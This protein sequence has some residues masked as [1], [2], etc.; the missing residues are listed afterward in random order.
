M[1]IKT[2]QKFLIGS[3]NLVY[4]EKGIKR[5]DELNLKEFLASGSKAK[6]RIKKNKSI[7]SVGCTKISLKNGVEVVLGV[8]SKLYT[9]SGW[10]EI[11][12]ITKD[13]YVLFK[14]ESYVDVNEGE[15]P[16][17]IEKSNIGTPISIPK[18][19]SYEFSKWLGMICSKGRF[20]EENG[21]VGVTSKDDDVIKEFSRLTY[22]IF[23]LEPDEYLDKR[24]GRGVFSFIISK[25]LVRF[26]KFHIGKKMFLRKVPSFILNSPI[27]TQLAFVEGL[28][29][30]G[31][32]EEKFIIAYC[33]ISKRLAEFSTYVLRASGHIVSQSVKNIREGKK[34]YYVRLLGKTDKSLNLNFIEEEKNEALKVA[35][36]KVKV[37]EG[38]DEFSVSSKHPSC[39]AVRNIKRR[40]SIVCQ[41]TTLDSLEIDYNDAYYYIRVKSIKAITSELQEIETFTKMGIVLEGLIIGS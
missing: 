33:G 37:P 8:D 31:Y 9:T 27:E 15:I 28:S 6:Q 13:D 29:L 2:N 36:Y 38:F 32:I 22:K 23:E 41:N 16:W 7:G 26:L 5:V 14:K 17:D 25:N 35:P 18:T 40:K 10:K 24:A 1:N 4:S 30:D 19:N 12:D 20:V 3:S 34:G 11:E 39:S 21:H